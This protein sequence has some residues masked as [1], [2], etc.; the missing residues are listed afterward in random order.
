M[1]AYIIAAGTMKML[2]RLDHGTAA[3]PNSGV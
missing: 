2:T 3:R 1:Q